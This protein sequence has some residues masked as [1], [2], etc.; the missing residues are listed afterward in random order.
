MS[1]YEVM[2]GYKNMATHRISDDDVKR[3]LTKD[4]LAPDDLFALL[5]ENAAP[6]LEQMA[7]IANKLTL[8]NFGKSM[9]LYT[10][11]YLSNYCVNSCVY[12]GFNVNNKIKRKKL[13]LEEVETETQ[14]I[15][16]LGLKH[17]LILTGEARD[18]TPFSYIKDCINILKRHIASISI[19]IF[20]LTGEEYK[21]LIDLGIDGLTIYQE[22]YDKEVY[23]KVHLSGPK[24]DYRFRLDAAERAAK[25]GIR[26][27]NIGALLGLA[28]FRNEAFIMAL[29]A[30]YL[31][32]KYPGVEVGISVPRI[33]PHLG[34]Y[35]PNIN[36]KDSDI[37]QI[38]LA[39]RLFM[40]RLGITLS[41][42]EQAGLRDALISLG[43]TKMSAS[44]TTAVGGHTINDENSKQFNISDTRSV[45]EIKS[46]LFSK[47]Y[48]PVLK[49]WVGN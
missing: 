43:I 42:R 6:Y 2:E 10:P 9:L 12:C 30:D 24:K 28:A 26:T 14:H 4:R 34:E 22:V 25:N 47:G 46:M 19:E 15:V 39:A 40:P 8:Q 17:V 16:S 5:S 38:I 29:H 49:D 36:V 45:S 48:Q 44:S 32:N 7:R 33:Q 1:F 20:P 31:Q 35:K 11:M 37:V 41:T 18:E 21:E 3:A 27:L 13:T 23:D